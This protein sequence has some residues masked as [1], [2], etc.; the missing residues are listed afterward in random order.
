M[1]T[2]PVNHV[3]IIMDGNGRW[4]ETQGLPRK[5]GHQQGVSQ[6]KEILKEA[7]ALGVSSITLYCFSTENWKRPKQ[8]VDFLMNLIPKHLE[9]EY[10][11]YK[12]N[13]IK[14]SWIGSPK[15]VPFLVR[16]AMQRVHKKTEN[17]DNLSLYLAINYGGRDEIIRGVQRIPWYKRI[18]KSSFTEEIISRHLDA[19]EAGEPDMIIRTGGDNRT[20]NFLLWQGAYSELFFTPTLWPDFSRE[21]FRTMVESMQ[22]RER[23]FGG[24]HHEH[25]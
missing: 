23:R 9:E 25:E 17:H 6:A 5:K 13:R 3:A 10:Q 22:S 1:A 7:I 16:K 4:A 8:E 12:T 24:L 14:V 18:R 21:E 15:G 19:P 2:P 20:S 11:F